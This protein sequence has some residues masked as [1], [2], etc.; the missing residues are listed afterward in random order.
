MLTGMDA[1][2]GTLPVMAFPGWN[3]LALVRRL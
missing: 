1:T 3:V 2:L